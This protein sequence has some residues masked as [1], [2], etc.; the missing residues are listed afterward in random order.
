MTTFVIGADPG[1]SVGYAAFLDDQRIAYGQERSDIA[2]QKIETLLVPYTGR[3]DIFAAIAGERYTP[4]GSPGSRTSQPAALQVLGALRAMAHK[5]GVPMM[6]QNPADAYKYDWLL[7]YG[8]H[9]KGS[10]VGCRDADDANS[11]TR[12]ALL[13]IATHRATTLDHIMQGYGV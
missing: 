8:L 11:A 12:H 9:L 7:A 1:E 13:W 6:L 3:P 4:V 5:Y 10:D 2:I